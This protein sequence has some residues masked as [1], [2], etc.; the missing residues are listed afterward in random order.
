MGGKGKSKPYVS[1]GTERYRYKGIGRSKGE[2]IPYMGY[3]G[4]CGPKGWD[5]SA[6]LVINRVWF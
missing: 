2:E 1:Y 6:I 3:I 5:F 4:M